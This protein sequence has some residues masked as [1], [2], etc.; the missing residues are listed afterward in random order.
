LQ[1][2]PR[3][4]EVIL[5]RRT[6]SVSARRRTPFFVLLG[7]ICAAFVAASPAA[8]QQTSC[9]RT[10]YAYAGLQDDRKAHGVA[11]TLVALENPSVAAG[12]VAGWVGVGGTEAG[13]GGVAEWLQTG[14]IAIDNDQTSRMYYEVTVAGSAPRYVELDSSVP[15][16]E[17]HRFAVLEMTKRHSWWRVWVDGKPVTAPIHLPGSHGAWY[18]QAVAENWNGNKGSC[19]AYDYRFGN[20][21]LARRPGGIWRALRSSYTFEDAGYRIEQTSRRPRSFVAASVIKPAAVREAASASVAPADAAPPAAD[22]PAPAD[23]SAAPV[24]P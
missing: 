4:S 23:P 7:L 6:L 24:S 16:G 2:F 8:G 21:R 11:A 10:S 5:I 17:K 22:P 19:N 1:G 3:L 18:P 15:T 14:L 20:V 9:G 13:P 12:H